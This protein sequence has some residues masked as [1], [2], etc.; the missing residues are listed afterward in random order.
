MESP[1]RTPTGGGKKLVF[2]RGLEV[3]RAAWFVG[4]TPRRIA[5]NEKPGE[6]RSEGGLLF[7]PLCALC[8]LCGE[9]RTR[10]RGLAGGPGPVDFRGDRESA[11]SHGVFPD[12]HR[13]HRGH[14]GG[15]RGLGF[16]FPGRSRARSRV[17][18]LRRPRG[19]D[20]KEKKDLRTFS[21]PIPLCSLCPLW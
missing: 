3:Q 6:K 18:G 5:E 16:G 20:S 15:K 1:Q 14:R 7:S 17:R 13:G 11:G 21:S 10:G 4:S 8:A 2:P 19:T 12:H 9:A